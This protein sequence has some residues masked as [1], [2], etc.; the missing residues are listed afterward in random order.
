MYLSRSGTA[1]SYGNVIVY[2][3]LKNCHIVFH[4]T[5]TILHSHQQCSR[6][7]NSPHP[8]LYLL[9]PIFWKV[10]ILMGVKCLAVSLIGDSWQH[11]KNSLFKDMELTDISEKK[12]IKH[13]KAM[14]E[15]HLEN[16]QN[17]QLRLVCFFHPTQSSSFLAPSQSLHFLYSFFSFTLILCLRKD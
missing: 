15:I 6:V 11:S 7:P 1:R 5:W 4:C 10:S 13:Q 3:F 9:S 14:V 2:F 8:C 12:I 17:L 16:S